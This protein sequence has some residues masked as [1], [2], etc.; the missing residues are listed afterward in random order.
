MISPFGGRGG[1]VA[2]ARDADKNVD[3]DVEDKVLQE[4]K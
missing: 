2:H 1:R 3:E 4:I